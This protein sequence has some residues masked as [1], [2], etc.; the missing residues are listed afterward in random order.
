MGVQAV[1]MKLKKA[2][3]AFTVETGQLYSEMRTQPELCLLGIL[4]R[5][6]CVLRFIVDKA[7]DAVASIFG[8]FDSLGT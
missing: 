5:P 4:V 1:V 8:K 7:L 2:I 3:R 6:A